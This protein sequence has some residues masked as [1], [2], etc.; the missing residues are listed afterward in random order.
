MSSVCPLSNPAGADGDGGPGRTLGG[1]FG[2]L[3]FF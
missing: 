2:L 1:M 3:G